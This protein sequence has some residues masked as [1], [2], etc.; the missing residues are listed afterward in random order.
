[1]SFSSNVQGRDS[2]AENGP[3]S[4]PKVLGRH[5]VALALGLLTCACSGRRSEPL[6]GTWRIVWV[7]PFMSGSQFPYLYRGDVKVEEFTSR[8]RYLGQDCVLFVA[9]RSDRRGLY[10]ACADRE[11]ILI[12]PSMDDYLEGQIGATGLGTDHVP[13]SGGLSISTKEAIR[14]ASAQPKFVA[15]WTL[16]PNFRGSLAAA[17]QGGVEDVEAVLAAGADPN[18]LD[19]DGCTALFYA[20]YFANVPVAARL[21]EKGVR[22]D[23]ANVDGDTSLHFLSSQPFLEAGPAVNRSHANTEATRTA[24]DI[25]TRL[26]A[27]EDVVGAVEDIATRLIERGAMIDAR[28][29][30][31]ET[32]LARAVRRDD[33]TTVKAL[34]DAG[35]NPGVLDN[36]GRS[37][38]SLASDVGDSRNHERI[39]ELVRLRLAGPA[40]DSFVRNRAASVATERLE[41]LAGRNAGI[42]ELSQLINEGADVNAAGYKGETPLMS[43]AKNHKTEE[44]RLF[45]ARGADPNLRDEQ[46]GTAL[47]DAAHAGDVESIRLLLTKGADVHLRTKEGHTALYWAE[48]MKRSECAAVLRASGGE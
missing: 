16:A 38:A 36:A 34:L 44:V 10:A 2:M 45:L 30:R 26:R 11:P 8:Y 29:A 9:G 42:A 23:V 47:M 48:F 4:F 22:A 40:Y 35:A 14:R 46:G 6:G 12:S 17:A 24:E 37:P 20:A 21:L 18:A 41:Y 1:M 5:A 25:N 19:R 7:S 39:A 33:A 27:R 31:G 43:S 32:P 3:R 15:G 28:N 13:L